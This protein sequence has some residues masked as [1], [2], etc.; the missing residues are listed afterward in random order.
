MSG[1]QSSATDQSIGGAEGMNIR[2]TSTTILLLLAQASLF[3]GGLEKSVAK[4]AALKT[5]SDTGTITYEYSS[6]L[7]DPVQKEQYTFTTFY[8]APRQ[9]LF[10]FRKGPDADDERLVVW[11]DAADFNTWW[12]ATKVHDTYPKGQGDNA[13]ALS[14]FPT[15]GSVMKIPPL[16]FSGAGLH[17][18]ITDF[19]LL[20]TDPDETV[21]GHRC[22]KLVG[23]VALAYG[24]GTVTASTPTTI[25]IDAES[26]L[27]RKIL[28]DNT[29]S[30]AVDRVTTTFEPEADPKIDDAKFK[31]APPSGN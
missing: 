11:A 13:F 20:R 17:G 2:I 21:N 25:W 30:G 24:T 15:K 14:S 23:E 9:F 1:R 28:E 16:L 27:V 7:S 4:Y 22:N 26:L 18:P 6:N 3:A 12:S 8:R 10:D 5:Y 31:F 29:K 19:K